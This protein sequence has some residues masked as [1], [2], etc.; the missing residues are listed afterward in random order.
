MSPSNMQQ[1]KELDAQVYFQMY[2]YTKDTLLKGRPLLVE[3]E[4]VLGPVSIV[5]SSDGVPY[6]YWAVLDIAHNDQDCIIHVVRRSLLMVDTQCANYII[7]C[8]NGVRY[9]LTKQIRETM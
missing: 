4:K 8:T 1:H 2:L 3:Y 7:I 5:Y 6:R 9:I